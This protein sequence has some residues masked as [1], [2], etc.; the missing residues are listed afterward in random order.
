MA[1]AAGM[2]EPDSAQKHGQCS[3]LV[4]YAKEAPPCNCAEQLRREAEAAAAAGFDD[5]GSEGSAFAQHDVQGVTFADDTYGGSEASPPGRRLMY[6]KSGKGLRE[7]MA[8]KFSGH[9]FAGWLG[10]RCPCGVHLLAVA[11][12]EVSEV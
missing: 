1:P 12:M 11:V 3:S 6:A 5:A 2:A 4:I 10:P 9:A 7:Q 8:G